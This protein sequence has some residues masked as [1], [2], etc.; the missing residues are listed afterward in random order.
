MTDA[1]FTVAGLP[2][3]VAE[4]QDVTLLM[5]AFLPGT[6]RPAS[7]LALLSHCER[8]PCRAGVYTRAASRHAGPATACAAP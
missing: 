8:V 4:R 2:M 6:P 7:L 5:Q 3:T 1:R